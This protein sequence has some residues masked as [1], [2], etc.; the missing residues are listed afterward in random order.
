M[1]FDP[2]LRKVSIKNLLAHHASKPILKVKRNF[3]DLLFPSQKV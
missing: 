3:L 1:G 2:L